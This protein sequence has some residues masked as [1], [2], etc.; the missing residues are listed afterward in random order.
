MPNPDYSENSTFQANPNGAYN[1][2]HPNAVIRDSD[3]DGVAGPI[4]CIRTRGLNVRQKWLGDVVHLQNII[5]QTFEI[6]FSSKQGQ[7]DLEKWIS[8]IDEF[9][10]VGGWRDELDLYGIKI[11]N[12]RITG[13]EFPTNENLMSNAIGRG[14]ANITVEQRQCADLSNLDNYSRDVDAKCYECIYSDGSGSGTYIQATDLTSASSYCV[15]STAG[16]SGPT[17]AQSINCSTM[18]NYVPAPGNPVN[19][20][21]HGNSK[22]SDLLGEYCEYIDDITE[23]FTFNY[24]KGENIEFTQSVSVKLFDA[25]PRGVDAQ[26][27]FMGTGG[28][29][30]PGKNVPVSQEGNLPTEYSGDDGDKADGIS[31]CR[32][33][34]PNVDDAL[35]LARRMLDENIPHFGIAFHGGILRELD[36][37]NVVAYYTENQNLITGE[38]SMTKKLTLLK[39]RDDNLNWSADYT[40]TL[41]IDQGGVATVA[42]RGTV[43]GYKKVPTANPEKVNDT[44]YENA[45]DG[46]NEVMGDNFSLAETRCVGFWE[47]HRE[48]YKN[49]YG[50]AGEPAKNDADYGLD[51]LDLHV[52]HP[53][54]KTRSFNAIS[55]EC[56]YS[57]SFTTSPNIFEKFMAD[58]VL[59]ASRDSAG[60]ITLSEK[61]TLTQYVPKGEDHHLVDSSGAVTESMMDF[62][63]DNP[64]Q[65]I[66]PD[67]FFG[68]KTRALAFYNGL[69]VDFSAPDDGCSEPLK[70]KS[71][72]MSW[73]PNGRGLSYTLN[74]VTD[75]SISCSFPDKNGVRKITTE[76]S[77]KIPERIRQEHPIAKWK[78]LV[79]DAEQTGLGER[80]VSLRA[81]LDRTPKVNILVNPVFPE[82]SLK[83][84]AE[85][86]KDEVIKVFADDSRLVA[87]DMF[88]KECKYTFNANND[89]TFNVTIGYLQQR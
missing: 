53:L 47:A 49:H 40:H 43:R 35:D 89:A 67:D 46:M 16:S 68:A 79:H 69:S 54:E 18:P 59:T 14:Q 70:I 36:Q 13:V 77:D 76:T 20:Y 64:I 10:D 60:A 39:H 24:G 58:R 45:L 84:L 73:S 87:D 28:P 48:F 5:T 42:E 62:K 3:G 57:I 19:D 33:G 8:K 51:N 86:A 78:M 82:K 15:S 37:Q 7:K 41:V 75:K 27:A 1:P 50:G 83:Y 9:E 32:V 12:C 11:P 52:G 2:G 26:K 29:G 23:D 6:L 66:F 61:N 38:V 30:E 65:V 21:V 71:R 17:G 88:L 80:T 22:V 31:V 55:Q 44:S 25:C 4:D 85:V 63:V 56:S 81:V 34:Q 74:W 72:N